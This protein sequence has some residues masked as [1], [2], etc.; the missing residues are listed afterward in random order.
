MNDGKQLVLNIQFTENIDAL[1]AKKIE[2]N[3]PGCI[4]AVVHNGEVI[5]KKGYGYA[6]LDH[7]VP[8][9]DD[10]SFYIASVSKQFTAMSVLLLA[11]AGQVDLDKSIRAY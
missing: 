5:F 9:T 3:A 11:E 8:I 4:V 7:M 1:V 10:T 2:E 6:N